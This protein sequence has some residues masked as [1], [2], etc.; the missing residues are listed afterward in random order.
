VFQY[1]GKENGGLEPG[2][3]K[4]LANFITLVESKYISSATE[5]K[6][7]DLASK[8]QYYP[9]DVIS[10]LGF[11]EAFGFLRED[12]DLWAY[13]ETNDGFWPVVIT[14]GNVPALA[15]FMRAW[16]LTLLMPKSTDTAGF[17]AVMGFA[18]RF[19][20]E[21][22]APGADPKKDMIAAFIKAGMTRGELIQEV[23]AEM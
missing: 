17:G 4:Q 23:Y 10:E 15:R 21:R 22:M 19:V 7:M 8:S 2:I 1:S 13:M 5:Y 16:P 12:R 3:D 20:D 11:G 6:P 9:L 14:L 18:N